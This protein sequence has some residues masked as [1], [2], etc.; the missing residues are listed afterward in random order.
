MEPPFHPCG[1]KVTLLFTS[2]R[3]FDL[4]QFSADLVVCV[5]MVPEYGKPYRIEFAF[6]RK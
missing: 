2:F 4:C 3:E 5:Y 6:T 1:L